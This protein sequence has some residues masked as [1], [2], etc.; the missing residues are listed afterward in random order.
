MAGIEIHELLIFLRQFG[1]VISGA[2][3]FWGAVFLLISRRSTGR[4]A[5]LWH[6]A[7]QKLLWIFFPAIL[8]Y[9]TSSILLFVEQCLFCTYAHEGISLP[10]TTGESLKMILQKQY[11]FFAAMFVFSLFGFVAFA[12]SKTRRLFLKNLW[13]YGFL[14]AAISLLL[15]FPWE[16]SDLLRKSAS[17]A[18]HSWH[19]ILTLGSVIVAD[20]IF[21]I[22][23]RNF[24]AI[25]P[26]I[27]RLITKGI[28]LG[29]GL[30]FISSALVFEEAFLP[31]ARLFFM[32]TI[33]GILMINGA[34]LS[35]PITYHLLRLRSYKMPLPTATQRIMGISGSISLA[36]WLSITAVD[37][38]RNIT[39]SYTQLLAGYF[40]FVI[41]LFTGRNIIHHLIPEE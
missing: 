26:R 29:L 33:I 8:F 34:I 37:I 1:L 17:I 27:F 19:S 28:W 39:L 5:A 14:F 21:I 40:L 13:G 18:L 20:Y 24:L 25:I 10:H 32:Q 36:G 23:G 41:I 2:A 31:N 3:A 16:A 35:G 4:K 11:P 9:S 22:F 12:F 15:I 6:G 30:D 7:A 38:F